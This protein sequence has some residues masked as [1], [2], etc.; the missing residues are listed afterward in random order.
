[1]RSL[2]S[3]PLPAVH[4]SQLPD[5]N[6]VATMVSARP[7]PRM[8]PV[9]SSFSNLRAYALQPENLPVLNL[10]RNRANWAL[11]QPLPANPDLASSSSNVGTGSVSQV[12]ST[13]NVVQAARS[14][15]FNIENLIL[16][17]R[18]DGAG[19]ML[20]QAK[21]RVLG[22]ANWLPTGVSSEKSADQANREVFLALAQ[23]LDLLWNDLSA[24]ERAQ[25][26]TP[27]RARVLQTASALAVLDREPYD[28]HGLTNVRYVVQALMLANGV[29]GFAEASPLLARFW[30]LNLH[31]LGIWGEDGSFGNGI[32]YSWYAFNSLVPFAASARVVSGINLYQVPAVRRSGEQLIA[33]TPPNMLQSSAFGDETETR[34]LY[35]YYS[36]ANYRLHA[37]Q[38]RDARDAWYWRAK[39][40]NVSAPNDASIWQL[41]LLGVDPSAPP[42]ALAP[43]SNDWFSVDSGLAA[44]HVDIKRSDRTS[45]FFRSS[46]FGAFNHSHADQNSLVYV[47]KGQPLLIGAGYYPYYNSPHHK[48][49]RATRFKNALT[50]DGGFG[51]SESPAGSAKPT[52]PFHSMDSSGALTRTQSLGN[53]AAVTGDATLAYRSV[54]ANRGTWVPA[55]S[56]A[57]R[58]VVMDKTN[59]VTLVYDWAASATARQWE[60]NFHSPNAF[61][62]DAST[63]K[64]ASGTS[65]VCLD[66]FGPATSFTQTNAWEVAPEVTQPA[67]AHGRFTVL[68]RSTEIAHLFVLR[69]GCK[70]HAVQVVQSGSLFVVNVNGRQIAQFD[71]RALSL[72]Q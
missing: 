25:I 47:S 19:A 46:R 28:S 70:A 31:T 18:L 15:R 41:L 49:T 43:S 10:L 20:A 16:V 56:H 3:E 60:L 54:D 67:Q 62:A 29:P 50:Y 1:M 2:V 64:A 38:T 44:M 14:E 69:E 51:Q 30:D 57:V 61:V 39:P 12:Q 65:S 22:L 6:A 55:L 8:L 11:T 9:N 26:A 71:K 45:V 17:G 24:A 63:V 40:A 4:V 21:T 27:L 52:D 58:S 5:G 66:R 53:L 72:S 68:T 33:F 36:A 48:N 34:N 13:R 35:D 32:A 23:G 37:Q 42:A 59:G 7:R